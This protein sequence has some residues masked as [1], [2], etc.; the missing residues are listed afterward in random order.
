MFKKKLTEPNLQI[1]RLSTTLIFYFSVGRVLIIT[2]LSGNK[3]SKFTRD[4]KLDAMPALLE[5][6]FFVYYV[7]CESTPFHSS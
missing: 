2:I 3:R 1:E 5:R 6:L 4:S 7:W